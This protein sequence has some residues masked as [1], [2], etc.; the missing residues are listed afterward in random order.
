MH[1]LH[2][3]CYAHSLTY[4]IRVVSE[5]CTHLTLQSDRRNSSNTLKYYN[6]YYNYFIYQTMIDYL[7]LSYIF[8]SFLLLLT[9]LKSRMQ[10]RRKF[11]NGGKHAKTWR[12]AERENEHYE[13][14]EN[15]FIYIKI[16]NSV[17]KNDFVY[18]KITDFVS[19]YSKNRATK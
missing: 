16:I 3:V 13:L 7:L 15:D 12:H 9:M 11:S 14:W 10:A 5:I 4:V 1:M 19:I 17:S 2:S 18:I 6:F 8:F